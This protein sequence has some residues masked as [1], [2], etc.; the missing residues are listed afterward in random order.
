MILWESAHS[1]PVAARVAVAGDFLPAGRLALPSGGWASAARGLAPYFDDIAVS[2]VNL[3]SALDAEDLPVRPATGLGQNVSAPSASLEYL[4]A[5][6]CGV[7]GLANNYSSDFRAAG[8]QR[9]RAAIARTGMVPLGAART[10]RND[11]DVFVWR[12]PGEISVGFWSAAIA[13]RDLATRTKPGVEPATLARASEAIN[14]LR[15]NGAGLSVALIHAGCLR[16][17]RADP[18]EAQLMDDIAS[19][20]FNILAAS[21]SHRIS[22]ARIINP[23]NSSP[24]F[25]FYGLGS[26]ASGYVA[27]DIER[28]GLIVVAGL[29]S[30]GDLARVEVRP[31]I[32]AASGFGEVPAPQTSDAI[33]SRFHSLSS[34]IADGSSERLFYR[35]MS[36]GLVSL[37]LR[38]VRAALRQSGLRGLARKARRMRMRHVKRLVRSVV[39]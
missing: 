25:C 7:V 20:G 34:E 18:A 14:L 8:A 19:S 37:Y 13:S 23:P 32:L 28:E 17:N 11:P 22:G 35:D 10:L 9:T 30:R 15:S 36:E 27:S 16:T 6:C 21:H 4:R 29:T 2:F 1:E 33:L 12:G 39:P 5:I 26:I 38:D 31:L 24:A 3:E